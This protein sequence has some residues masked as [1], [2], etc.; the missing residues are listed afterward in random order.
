MQLT[1]PQR[2]LHIA[3]TLAVTL[4]EI[5]AVVHCSKF[6]PRAWLPRALFLIAAVL[7][8]GAIQTLIRSLMYKGSGG[9]S[10]K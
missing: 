5:Y 4:L 6:V 7:I 3:F 10:E 8:C 2:R 1:F 9:G